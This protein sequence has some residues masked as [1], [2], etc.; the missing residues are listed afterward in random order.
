VVTDGTREQIGNRLNAA[1]RMKRKTGLVISRS[2]RLEMI[3]QQKWIEIIERMAA[4]TPLESNARALDNS[5]RFD[6]FSYFSRW[7]FHLCTSR[8]R[9]SSAR[10]NLAIT[11]NND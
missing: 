6:N 7:R 11:T 4:D 3:E 9:W 10:Q 5:L 1:M 8:V 2:R